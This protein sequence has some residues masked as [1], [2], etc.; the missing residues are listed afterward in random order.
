[1]SME[2]LSRAE[3]LAELRA[4]AADNRTALQQQGVT[5]LEGSYHGSGDEGHYDFAECVGANNTPSEYAVPDSV[6]DLFRALY[7][8]VVAGNGYEDGE[9]GGGRL[10]LDVDTGKARHTSYYNVLVEENNEEEEL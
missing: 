7:T 4:W 10:I 2:I 3:I 1:M 6:D 8:D 5:A 9:G